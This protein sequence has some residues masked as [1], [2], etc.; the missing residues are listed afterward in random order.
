MYKAASHAD[1]SSAFLC[2]QII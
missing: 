2:F 1:L